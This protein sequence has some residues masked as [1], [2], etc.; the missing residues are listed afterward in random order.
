MMVGQTS[1]RCEVRGRSNIDSTV[2]AINIRDTRCRFYKPEYDA[3]L[4]HY[5][6]LK[7]SGRP[8]S[9]NT[10]KNE[11]KEFVQQSF[12]VRGIEVLVHVAGSLISSQVRQRRGCLVEE[13]F[14]EP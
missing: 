2:Y 7:E 10:F 4:K 5:D 11:R 9:L 12:K 3:V 8:V 14:V 13:V 1:G 6:D